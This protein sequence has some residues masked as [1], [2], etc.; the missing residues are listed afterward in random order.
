MGNKG[1]QRKTNPELIALVASLREKGREEGAPIWRDI[2]QRLERPSRLWA[3]V[4]VGRLE[5][6]VKED[7]T[8]VIPGKVLSAGHVGRPIK[9]AAYG[10]SGKAR[11]KINAAG[12]TCLSLKELAAERTNGT[13]CRILG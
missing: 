13:K 4:N 2:A 3:E 5:Q 6:H 11:E 1:V 8:A 7:E 10:F 12:G 9:V